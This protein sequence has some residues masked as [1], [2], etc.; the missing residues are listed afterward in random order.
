ME[1]RRWIIACA[2]L[3]TL[4]AC[5]EEA[6]SRTELIVVVDSDLSVP[7]ELDELQIS[8][9]GPGRTQHAANAALGTG[10]PGLPR[11]LALAH[12]G[13]QLG[14]ITITVA[15]LAGGSVVL[16]RQAELSFV[17]GRSLVLPLHLARQCVD[18]ACE[19]G[20]SCTE[21]GCQ[22]IAL[23]AESLDPWRGDKPTLAGGAMNR[24]AGGEPVPVD[25]GEPAPLD[26]SEP[27]AD[28]GPGTDDGGIDAMAEAGAG[29]DSGICV[30]RLETCNRLDDDC[31]GR[32]DE[33]FDLSVDPD[34]CGACGVI[35]NVRRG[36]M[37][38]A[39]ACVRTCR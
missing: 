25:A 27:A 4:L 10:Q 33:S 20:E 35:C 16:T 1:V 5:E 14:P 28:A 2:T 21:H 31:N 38:C 8:T 39:G 13:G 22:R 9:Q 7:E 15:G 29:D 32:V 18:V 26:A 19:R 23:D 12:E 34:N 37:C 3:A 11:Y 17:A 6:R 24:D 30:P 36:D